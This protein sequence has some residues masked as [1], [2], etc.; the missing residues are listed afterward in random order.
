MPESRAVRITLRSSGGEEIS[1]QQ[2]LGEVTFVGTSIYIR[3]EEPEKGPTGGVTRTTVKVAGQ[4]LKL[5]RHGEVES[6]QTFVQGKRLP[7][8]Y[9]SPYT[10][11]NM[12][13]DT[14][15]LEIA[16][17][18]ASGALRWTYDLYVYEELSGQFSI[19]LQI[20]EEV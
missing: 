7:G 2:M 6:Q 12:S 11:F 17:S 4:E 18:G 9:R 14:S 15:L 19:S 20:Q 16:L 3:Y 1:E 5:L 8:F 13:A 10:S